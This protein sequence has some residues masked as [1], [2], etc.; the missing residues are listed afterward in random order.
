MNGSW[1]TK[2]MGLASILAAISSALTAMFD[3]NP[4]TNPDWSLVAAAI[5]A[6]VGNFLSRQ[7]NVTSEEAGAKPK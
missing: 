4:A 3:G 7:N 6:G 1:Q 2:M 5:T